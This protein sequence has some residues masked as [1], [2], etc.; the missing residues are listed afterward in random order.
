MILAITASWWALAL[1]PVDASVPSWVVRTRAACFGTAADGLPDAGGWVLLIGEP[2]GMLG[3][4][5]VVWGDALRH[6]LRML[7]SRL[8]GRALALVAAVLMLS[9]VSAAVQRVLGD[10]GQPFVA[11]P[12]LLVA[13]R[14]SE[15]APVPAPMLSLTDQH[16]RP[17]SLAAVRGRRVLLTFAYAH[18][19][20][21]C[22]TVV[23]DLQAAR[24]TAQASDA[25]LIIV[26]LDPWRDAPA[27]LG[28][29]AAGWQL[30]G[31]DRMLSGTVDEV[32][33]VHRAWG[34]TPARNE[35]TGEV[36][37]VATVVILDGDGR[38]RYQL[39]Q[40][41][42]RAAELLRTIEPKTGRM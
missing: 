24:R 34:V 10:R 23:H 41:W 20:T 12:A 22:P 6:D 15:P 3:V 42:A 25:V 18:C 35:Q 13:S 11:A 37:H 30:A 26:T 1:W 32:Q 16:G 27:R 28:A 38:V 39:A 29:I 33:R 31:D 9:G 2:I 17:F 14:W 36:T 5:V 4:L 21:I 19:Q 7:W 40:D 8:W